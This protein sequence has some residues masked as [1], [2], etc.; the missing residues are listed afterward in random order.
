MMKL[1]TGKGN[2]RYPNY[3]HDYWPCTCALSAVNVIVT[4]FAV[5]CR[6]NLFILHTPAESGA[7][8]RDSSHFSK[9]RPRIMYGHTYSKIKDQQGKVANPTRGDLSRENAYFPVPVCA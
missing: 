5:L 7:Y 8:L 6:A 4:G 3:L 1:K 2:I 9:R